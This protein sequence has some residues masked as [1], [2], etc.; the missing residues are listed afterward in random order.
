MNEPVPPQEQFNQLGQASQA[1]RQPLQEQPLMLDCHACKTQ[2]GMTKS[3][4]AR[5]SPVVQVIGVLLL[6]PSF[7]GIFFGLFSMIMVIASA[8]T[9][10]AS[11]ADDGTIASVMVVS[12]IGVGLAF[13]I[14]SFIGGLLGWLLLMRKK[15]FKCQRCGF[16]LDRS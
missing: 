8:F 13:I 15:V 7:L 1:H 6:I 14:P 16:I 9:A 2:G 4:V 10:P 12:G 5:F 3:N 11:G